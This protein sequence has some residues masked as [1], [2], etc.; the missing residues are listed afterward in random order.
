MK[1]ATMIERFT[2][3]TLNSRW[4]TLAQ[5]V[6]HHISFGDGENADN[7]DGVWASVTTPVTPGT[8]FTI[9]HNLGRKPVGV[10]LKQKDMPVDVYTG[11]TPWN[12]QT[13]TLKATAASAVIK[14]FIH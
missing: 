8:D 2:H 6:N 13:I 12:G 4:A 3:A 1:I 10:D 5:A 9:T 11:S 7:I 14:L